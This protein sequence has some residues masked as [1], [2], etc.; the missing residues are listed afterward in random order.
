MSKTVFITGV[1]TGLGRAFAEV[2]LNQGYRVIGTLRD[3]DATK[4]GSRQASGRYRFRNHRK[5]D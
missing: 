2:L 4:Y 5:Y 3:D 1:S